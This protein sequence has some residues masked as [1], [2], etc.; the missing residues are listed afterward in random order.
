M[1]LHCLRIEKLRAGAE[2]AE[3]ACRRFAA[4][5]HGL[6][7]NSVNFGIF[8]DAI[9]LGLQPELLASAQLGQVLIANCCFSCDKIAKKYLPKAP[10]AKPAKSSVL[11]PA[12]HGEDLPR[13]RTERDYLG[14]V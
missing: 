1:Q 8:A 2:K 5:E 13:K 6:R 4:D 10:I 3:L 9:G 7:L 14:S 11:F 12:A